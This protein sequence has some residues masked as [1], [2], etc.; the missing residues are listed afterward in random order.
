MVAREAS[1]GQLSSWLFFFQRGRL[2]FKDKLFI[3]I[4]RLFKQSLIAYLVHFSYALICNFV[5]S[6]RATLKD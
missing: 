5:V 6:A 4:S 2:P 3:D 1:L